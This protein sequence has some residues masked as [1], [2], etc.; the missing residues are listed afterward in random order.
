LICDTSKPESESESTG[1]TPGF[2]GAH[3]RRLIVP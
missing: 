2:T 1:K 3:H